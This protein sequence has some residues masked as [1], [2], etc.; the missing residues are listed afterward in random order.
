VAASLVLVPALTIGLA[1]F[2]PWKL[3]THRTVNEALPDVMAPLVTS[4]PSSGAK[5][6]A[7]EKQAP[8]ILSSGGFRSGE[9]KTIGTA[10]V[11]RLGD[12][13]LI[14]RLTNFDTSDGPDVHVILS[15]QPAGASDHAVDKGRYL[16]LGKLKGTRGNQNYPI[17]ARTALG[18]FKSVVIW[19]D[20]F[21]VTFGS[22]NLN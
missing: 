15:D 3:F 20:R 2:Q 5:S 12:A 16:K 9:H 6:A 11:I 7:A 4:A 22:A 8:E 19:C 18:G 10:S 17:P 21:N 13:S 14:V 1:L